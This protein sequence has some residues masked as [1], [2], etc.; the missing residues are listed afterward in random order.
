MRFRFAILVL[1]I[2]ASTAAAQSKGQ[3]KSVSPATEVE[4]AREIADSFLDAVMQSADDQ[5]QPLV[6]E[7]MWRGSYPYRVV[8]KMSPI[9]DADRLTRARFTGETLSPDRD[10]VR[11]LGTLTGPNRAVEFKLLV[12][13]NKEGKWRV[14]S[15]T[16]TETAESLEKKVAQNAELQW[17]KQVAAD[18]LADWAKGDEVNA[19]LFFS[20]ELTKTLADTNVLPENWI[21]ERRGYNQYRD[22][23]PAFT[24]VQFAPGGNEAHL[25]GT[26]SKL[27]ECHRTE[28]Q[29]RLVK[30]KSWRVLTFQTKPATTPPLKS[31][32]RVGKLTCDAWSGWLPRSALAS[33]ELAGPEGLGVLDGKQLA[34]VR[35]AWANGDGSPPP[36]VDFAAVVPVV[37]TSK[38]GYLFRKITDITLDKGIGNLGYSTH[39]LE[40]PA[41]HFFLS[42]AMVPREGLSAIQANSTRVVLG[43]K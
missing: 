6:T 16:A 43:A 29:V 2:A 32:A 33:A 4:W 27:D 36:A 10:E 21:R 28:F 38:D 3:P 41:G 17:A 34:E 20:S 18:F 19:R 40:S 25:A 7:R 11:F 5:F 14:D 31:V 42:I 12:Q 15:F 23:T 35:K 39:Q 22:Q 24:A 1:I 37:M 13:K 30:E 8:Y 26:V 9:A